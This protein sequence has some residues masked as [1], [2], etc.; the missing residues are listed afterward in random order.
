MHR[1]NLCYARAPHV[2][3]LPITARVP[4]NTLRHSRQDQ[5]IEK[6]R[7][8]TIIYKRIHDLR[9]SQLRNVAAFGFSAME[10]QSVSRSMG[11][12]GNAVSCRS[13]RT[14]EWPPHNG[15]SEGAKE[16][17]NF[18]H[19][20]LIY[21]Q[22]NIPS[23]PHNARAAAAA[24]AAASGENSSRGGRPTQP[25]SSGQPAAASRSGETHF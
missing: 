15:M 13:G 6:D 22:P 14:M 4:R 21:R 2:R 20:W 16:A 8:S 9:L 25:F 18:E 11:T 12:S 1:L 17:S 3:E 5:I 10:H 23:A 7:R 19:T 24:A